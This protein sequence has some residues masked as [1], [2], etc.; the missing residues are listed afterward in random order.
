MLSEEVSRGVARLDDAI[1]RRAERG[2]TV[3]IVRLHNGTRRKG[4]GPG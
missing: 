3:C 2:R 1:G 4:V